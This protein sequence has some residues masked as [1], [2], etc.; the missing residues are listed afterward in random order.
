[1]SAP[2]FRKYRSTISCNDQNAPA[3]DG[4][5]PGMLLTVDCAKYLAYPVGGSPKREVVEG[6]EY[7]EGNFMFYRP[8]LQMRVTAHTQSEAEYEAATTWSL[9]LE[10]A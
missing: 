5:W 1:M 8:R 10:E 9:E 7:R 6:S 2:Q 3:L 4:V